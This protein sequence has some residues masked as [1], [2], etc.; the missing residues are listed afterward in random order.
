MAVG[1][2]RTIGSPV[3]LFF[4]IVHGVSLFLVMLGVSRVLLGVLEL[5]ATHMGASAPASHPTSKPALAPLLEM[6]M[7]ARTS[8]TTY[9][10]RRSFAYDEP[11]YERGAEAMVYQ[12]QPTDEQAADVD[13]AALAVEATV[14]PL[15]TQLSYCFRVPLQSLFHSPV[16]IYSRTAADDPAN[17]AAAGV[18]LLVGSAKAT[19]HRYDGSAARFYFQH[20]L[21]ALFC[22][23]PLALLLQRRKFVLDFVVTIYVVYWLLTDVMLQAVLGGGT[24][25]WWGA[26]LVGMATMYT[27]TYVICRRKEMQEV[28]LSGG[29]AATASN[30][31]SS[32]AG[33]STNLASV[34]VSTAT[35]WLKDDA[36]EME[37]IRPGFH[38]SS[39]PHGG[40]GGATAAVASSSAAVL[41]QDNTDGRGWGTA[42][43]TLPKPVVV[44]VG[45]ADEVSFK[46]KSV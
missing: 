41:F 27:T 35:T 23:C 17:P 38:D 22:A 8:A 11:R 19:P 29:A 1:L 25:H 10:P 34:L 15:S 44:D 9:L 31:S 2:G 5:S 33:T 26:C 30:G 4:Q 36:R 20:L 12:Q 32:G 37:E 14:L 39:S 45:G 16:A 46:S 43:S 21:T 3:Y 42:G 13:G 24:W 18:E 6:Q 28:K 7:L 40:G